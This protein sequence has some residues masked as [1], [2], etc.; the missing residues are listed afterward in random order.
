M[1]E[2]YADVQAV[3]G[4]RRAATGKLRITAS[5]SFAQS[6]LAGPSW[7]FQGQYPRIEVELIAVERAV[8]LV[9]ERID[10]AVR[11]TNRLTMVS[12]RAGSRVAARWCVRHP[13]T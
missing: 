6:Y 9:D 1:L 10:L 2:L 8:D 3:S 13:P 5:L 7:S 11:I 4:Q 12:S